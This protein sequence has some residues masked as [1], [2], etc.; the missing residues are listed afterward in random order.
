MKNVKT[1]KETTPQTVP[2]DC[3]KEILAGLIVVSSRGYKRVIY[4]YVQCRPDKV[5]CSEIDC[6]CQLRKELIRSLIDYKL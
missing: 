4:V 1:N 3:V 5:L 6:F 2:S